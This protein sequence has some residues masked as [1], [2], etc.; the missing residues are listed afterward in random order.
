MSLMMDV[1][2]LSP[3]TFVPVGHTTVVDKEVRYS[4]VVVKVTTLVEVYVVRQEASAVF[5][6]ME[7]VIVE[8]SVESTTP[9]VSVAVVAVS[10]G[11]GDG[12][13]RVSVIVP[14]PTFVSC[15]FQ[16]I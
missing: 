11:V 3:D 12:V 16:D 13:S 7:D 8:V 5:A 4:I 10:T 9:P 2:H 6:H 14:V 15:Y 1:V